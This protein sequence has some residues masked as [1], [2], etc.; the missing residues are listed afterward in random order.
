MT[1]PFINMPRNA[2]HDLADIMLMIPECTNLCGI[3]GSLRTF[4]NSP[5]PSNV[6]L[7]PC[8]K[9]TKELIKD[10]DEWAAS[11]PYLTTLSSG[12][13]IVEANMATLS[14]S[15]VK[16]AFEGS[17]TDVVLP[18]SFVALTIATFES[19]QLTLTLLL[20]K[21]DTQDPTLR[22]ANAQ[23]SLPSIPSRPLLPSPSSSA[24]FNQA[25]RSAEIILKTAGHLEGTKSVGF[26]FIRSVTPVVVVAI[27]GPTA[28]LTSNAMAMLKRW[29]E[30]RGMNGLVG[31]WMHL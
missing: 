16:P 4:F 25:I 20:H 1:I 11:Y 13:H 30:K 27:L 22:D 3:E 17:S 29:G 26:D 6:D 31:A 12:L 23:S 10:L 15:G 5:F 18:D 19:V 14:V 21:L 9:R 8:R 7:E 28:E 24:L 2:H